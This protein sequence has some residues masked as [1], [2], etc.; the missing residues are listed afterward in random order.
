MAIIGKTGSGKSSLINAIAGNLKHTTGTLS[1]SGSIAY[2]PQEPFLVSGTVRENILFGKEFNALRYTEAI[3]LSQLEKDIEDQPQ[4]DLTEVGEAGGK[5]SGGQKQRISIARAIYSD[6]DIYLVD[7]CFSALDIEVAK[8]V[9]D[10]VF[11]GVLKGKTRILATYQL[12]FARR[13]DRVVLMEGCGVAGEGKFGDL[14]K[15][16]EYQEFTAFLDKNDK[17]EED[18]EIGEDEIVG[19]GSQDHLKCPEATHKLP[20]PPTPITVQ[21][22]QKTEIIENQPIQVKKEKKSES[23]KSVFS[24]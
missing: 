2:I 8:K 19:L 17:N 6:C 21:T 3:K 9:F 14:K 11:E 1:T 5:L 18:N 22:P 20:N 24:S 16:A 10:G 12:H 4:K 15:M 23:E 7:D 13:A